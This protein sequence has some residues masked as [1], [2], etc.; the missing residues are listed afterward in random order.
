VLGA[1][2]SSHGVTAATSDPRAN[3]PV[4]RSIESLLLSVV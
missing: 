3:G 2:L 4:I 1:P